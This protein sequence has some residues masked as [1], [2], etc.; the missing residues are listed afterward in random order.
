MPEILYGRQ[1]VREVLR[2]GRRRARTLYFRHGL[3][4]TAELD[5]MRDMA[6]KAGVS[7]KEVEGTALGRMTQG[8]HDQGVALEAE[9]YPYADWKALLKR[10]QTVSEPPFILLLDHIEDPQ[11]LGSILRTAET[12]GVDGVL[13]PK[14][15]A[16]GVTAAVVR[17][18]AG[19]V[20]HM[21]VCKVVNL[22]Q[23]MKTLKEAE[24]WITGLDAGADAAWCW[25]VDLKGPTGLVIGSEGKGL[26]RLVRENCDFLA[27]LPVQGNV[28]SLNASNAAAMA[29]YE[30]VRQRKV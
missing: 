2:A 30:L 18:S 16:V 12:A 6:A 25:D 7:F 4:P 13:L 27:R 19:A 24:I 5:D 3:K 10:V 29:M 15:R 8:G 28:A 26:H 11:N 14:D 17:A 21:T 22:V 20:E 23:A 1:P 9:A